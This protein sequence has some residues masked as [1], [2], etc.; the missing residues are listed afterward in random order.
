MSISLSAQPIFPILSQMNAVN[1][2]TFFSFKIHS[3][4]ACSKQ[5]VSL[6]LPPPKT[7]YI[8]IFSI[9]HAVYP[10]YLNLY[11]LITLQYLIMITNYKAVHLTAD[12]LQGLSTI[13]K[14]DF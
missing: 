10:V 12:A 2:Y 4:I 11:D 13:S 1:A 9:V 14:R 5:T 8:F 6:S 3:E 7:L